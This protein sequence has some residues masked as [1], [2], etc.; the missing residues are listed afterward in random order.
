[1][2][3]GDAYVPAPLIALCMHAHRLLRPRDRARCSYII[4][5][6]FF[7]LVLIILMNIIFGIIIDTFSELRETRKERE[8]DTREFCFI[9]G[10]DKLAFAKGNGGPGFEHHIKEEH[11]L[12]SYL[13]FIIA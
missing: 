4:D 6:L 8:R 13:K 9:C 5:L 12:W 3:G 2:G 7:L 1:M 11:C 10:H